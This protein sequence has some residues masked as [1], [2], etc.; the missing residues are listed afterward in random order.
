MNTEKLSV[1]KGIERLAKVYCWPDDPTIT[2]M[3]KYEFKAL[4]EFVIFNVF[5]KNTFFAILHAGLRNQTVNLY[6]H[7]L[8]SLKEDTPM[9][10]F[11][12]AFLLF[13]LIGN[14]QTRS[15]LN[16]IS[17]PPSTYNGILESIVNLEY[18]SFVLSFENYDNRQMFQILWQMRYILYSTNYAWEHSEPTEQL[19]SS[20]FN[21]WTR[22]E[23][24]YQSYF[25]E[26]PEKYEDNFV[27]QKV[28]SIVGFEESSKKKV[29]IRLPKHSSFV[30]DIVDEYINYSEKESGKS[31]F[32]FQWKDLLA[33]FNDYSDLP[34]NNRVNTSSIEHFARLILSHNVILDKNYFMEKYGIDSSE[35]DNQFRNLDV[36]MYESEDCKDF[37]RYILYYT[38]E[39]L[40]IYNKVENILDDDSKKVLKSI[41]YSSKY[42]ELLGSIVKDSKADCQFKESGEDYD[43]VIKQWRSSC[44][45]GEHLTFKPICGLSDSEI[46]NLLNCLK[47]KQFISERSINGNT[48]DVLKGKKID[49][50]CIEFEPI[51]WEKRSS[52]NN[53]TS[54]ASVIN[55]LWLLGV[56]DDDIT[57]DRLNYCFVC[58]DGDKFVPFKSNNLK[59]KKGERC[60]IS[61][62]NDELRTIIG[63]ALKDNIIVNTRLKKLAQSE[64]E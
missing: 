35:V 46:D 27:R 25:C 47:D 22:S 28:L 21:E 39:M 40:Y 31:L 14:K 17:C 55:F 44:S 34:V 64:S 15:I 12:E 58:T 52:K 50:R 36:Y 30:E 45:K 1:K 26:I 42:T 49:K 23:D 8:S 18:E 60:R 53:K 38:W 43:R 29:R 41:L 56:N 11:K 61:E 32:Y 57:V 63:A 62:Y 7:L 19:S 2:D 24:N 3:D 48:R 9:L 33:E 4:S 13:R 54:K 6:H 5:V 37:G 20:R 10:T 16:A 51:L 59:N